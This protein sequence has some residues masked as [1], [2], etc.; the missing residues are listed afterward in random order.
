M[1]TLIFANF[2]QLM[3]FPTWNFIKFAKKN[4]SP[5]TE[6]FSLTTL[7]VATKFGETGTD[8]WFGVETRLR[9][10]PLYRLGDELLLYRS[11]SSSDDDRLLLLIIH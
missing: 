3:Q 4:K 7:F 1:Q 5:A 10:N 6:E 11:F 9:F 2:S 8:G